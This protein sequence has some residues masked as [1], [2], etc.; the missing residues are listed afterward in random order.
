MNLLLLAPNHLSLSHL[1]DLCDIVKSYNPVI[2]PRFT[3]GYLAE[4]RIT[5]EVEDAIKE[6]ESGIDAEDF[7]DLH[8]PTQPNH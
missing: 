1:W 8:F 2:V 5:G 6:I 3:G 4:I 7:I